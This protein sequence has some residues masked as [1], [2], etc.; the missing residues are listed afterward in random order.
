[1]FGNSDRGVNQLLNRINNLILRPGARN[2]YNGNA[3]VIQRTAVNSEVR[4]RL[5][6]DHELVAVLTN[7][8]VDNPERVVGGSAIALIKSSFAILSSDDGRRV[9]ARNCFRGVTVARAGPS[10]DI[11]R[12]VSEATRR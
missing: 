1:M 5:D 7:E 12:F 10:N 11:T 9:I 2:Q 3:A 4:L 8:R 6:G